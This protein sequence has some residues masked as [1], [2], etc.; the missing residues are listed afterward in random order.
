MQSY[1]ICKKCVMDTSDPDIQFD[2]EGICNHC[3]QA[4]EYLSKYQFTEEQEAANL[5]AIKEQIRLAKKGPYDCLV[6]VS[7][8]VDSS[9]VVYL[10]WKMGLNPLC[11]HFDNGWNSNIAVS[12]IHKMIAQCGF[13]LQTYVIDWNE[14]RDLQ[15]AFF[16]AG[17][18][19]IEMLT[20]HAI[21]AIMFGL[22]KKNKL[23][24]ILS[25]T[26]YSTEH[27]LPASWVWRKQD[28]TNIKHIHQ[29][30]GSIRRLKHYPTLSSWKFMLLRNFKL[31][32]RYIEILNQVNY[33]K[34]KAIS[35]LSE[36]F[37]WQNYGGKHY[38]S[39]FT[40]FYQAYYL[41]EKFGFDKRKVH[42]SA[43]I[44]NGEI[45]REEAIN[46]LSQPPVSGPEFEEEK[47][48][49]LKKLGFSEKEFDDIMSSPVREHTYYPS[50]EKW[51]QLWLS[52]KK[53][54]KK[55]V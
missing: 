5:A 35:T 14:F 32:F 24:Y 53:R 47:A 12:N 55:S 3:R 48:Y 44:R 18:V 30:F 22:A 16:K 39:V 43:Q 15:R 25:G 45:A 23:K 37:G 6:G 46:V 1:Q 29:Q 20:D 21:T 26:N 28:L 4:E 51:R 34:N 9:Y 54:V 2:Q 40:K 33:S 52:F 8:G 42:L 50:D 11:V 7:G 49:V 41:P 27:G 36:Q 17:V 19:D 31:G 13:D 10:A 38:E